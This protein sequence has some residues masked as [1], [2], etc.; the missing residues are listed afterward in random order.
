MGHFRWGASWG[1]NVACRKTSRGLAWPTSRGTN[2]TLSKKVNLKTKNQIQG[3]RSGHIR[4]GRTTNEF[5]RRGKH[6][7]KISFSID[8]VS[9][10]S[11]AIREVTRFKKKNP[12]R[13][14]L[15]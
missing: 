6:E 11:Q 2:Q 3:G 13:A 1:G 5:R 7:E 15:P 12:P 10:V 9:G 8:Q 14:N 4:K